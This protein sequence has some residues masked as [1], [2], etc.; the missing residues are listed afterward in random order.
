MCRNYLVSIDMS[1]RSTGIVVMDSK[2]NLID[3]RIIKTFNKVNKGDYDQMIDHEDTI[4]HVVDEIMEITYQQDTRR[5][6][7]E[8]L[9]HQGKSGMKDVI[10]GLFWA[11]RSTIR[12]ESPHIYI[13]AIP[14]LTWRS[15][16]L[17]PKEVRESNTKFSPKNKAI[18]KATLEKLSKKI[19]VEFENYLESE[20][21]HKDHIFDLTDAYFMAKYRNS[22]D[23]KSGL[24]KA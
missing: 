19:R 2:D 17:T 11:I 6:V 3:Y 14:V 18:K 4:N 13:G 16:V 21:F 7:I 8:G 23:K 9:S 1:L 15:K 22:L 12:R 5:V 10:A 20:G 24:I